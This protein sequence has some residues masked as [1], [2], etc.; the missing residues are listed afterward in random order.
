VPCGCEGTENLYPNPKPHFTNQCGCEGKENLYPHSH[1]S[2]TLPHVINV[3]VGVRKISTLTATFLMSYQCFH[4]CIVTDVA[5]A[6][7][8]VLRT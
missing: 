3:A 2:H 7:K 5:V 6:W 4:T 1:I 8:I